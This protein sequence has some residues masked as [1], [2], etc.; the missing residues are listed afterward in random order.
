MLGYFL[1]KNNNNN[2][3]AQPWPQTFPPMFPSKIVIT[4]YVTFKSMTHFELM[5]E[6][7]VR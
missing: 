6:Y 1:L 5:S 7:G 2:N 4:L 3:F